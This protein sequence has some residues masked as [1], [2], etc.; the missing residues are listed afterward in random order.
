[1]RDSITL[2]DELSLLSWFIVS[3]WLY[4]VCFVRSGSELLLA[5]T[6]HDGK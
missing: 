2:V 6:A 1:M 4:V 5:L 3:V